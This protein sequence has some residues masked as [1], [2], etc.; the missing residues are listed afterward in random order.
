MY[1]HAYKYAIYLMSMCGFG[2]RNMVLILVI[3][4]FN[5]FTT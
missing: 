2:G 3:Q 5:S 1:V 4:L